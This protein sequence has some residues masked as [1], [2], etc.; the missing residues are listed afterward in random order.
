M[1]SGQP[2]LPADPR[3]LADRVARLLAGR[4][5]DGPRVVVGIAGAPGAGKSTLA[6]AV[7]DRLGPRCALVGMDGFHLAQSVLDSAG[8]TPV[9]GAPETFD[10]GGYLAL[11]QRLVS[12]PRE[13]VYAP[14]F[15]RDLEEPIAGA[16]RIGVDV[17]VILTE[18]NYLLLDSSPWDRLSGLLTET[19]YLDTPEDVRRSRLIARH[20]GFGRAQ[21]AAR[22]RVIT[23]SDGVNARLVI[24]SR[25][26]ADLVLLP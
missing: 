9:K 4:P 25:R 24:S 11:L 3:Q 15:R 5:G 7:A 2:A 20:V 21:Q 18:G 17:D 23:G 16:V 19:W 22:N 13:L 8:L 14:Q 1:P 12:T 6:A 26:R 10:V